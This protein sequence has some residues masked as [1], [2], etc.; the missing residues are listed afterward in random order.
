MRSMPR[1]VYSVRCA[2][3]PHSELDLVCRR[4]WSDDD[5]CCRSSA[6]GVRTRANLDSGSAGHTGRSVSFVLLPCCII[7]YT[8]ACLRMQRGYICGPL[9]GRCGTAPCP[10]GLR[11]RGRSL[12]CLCVTPVANG[13]V[14]V[15][16]HTHVD[17]THTHTHTHTHA[18]TL[19]HTH[20]QDIPVLRWDLGFFGSVLIP[21]AL[22]AGRLPFFDDAAPGPGVCVCVCVCVVLCVCVCVCGLYS[23][24][25]LTHFT[26]S[27]GC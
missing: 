4:C 26:R 19:T 3:I 13:C 14:V 21:M 8:V 11:W 24:R 17:S 12:C 10:C 6:V 7:L 16:R 22:A 23:T 20:T 1:C 25:C 9:C 27:R 18:R 15:I 2:F 5:E